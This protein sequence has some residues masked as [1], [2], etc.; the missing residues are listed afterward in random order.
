MYGVMLGM[1]KVFPILVCIIVFIFSCFW[2]FQVEHEHSMDTG[3]FQG[4][5]LLVESAYISA[6]IGFKKPCL[7]EKNSSDFDGGIG[8]GI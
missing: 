6:A 2:H 5:L 7:E 1:I 3:S 4:L 8:S